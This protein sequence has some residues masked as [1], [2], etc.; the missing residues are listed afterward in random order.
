MGKIGV[1]TLPLSSNNYGGIVQAYALQRKLKEEG[2]ADV[3]LLDRRQNKSLKNT[4]IIG[5]YKIF[6]PKYLKVHETIN[7]EFR[8]FIKKHIKS[9]PTFSSHKNLV[10]FIKTH[11]IDTLVT[12]SDQVWRTKYAKTIYK[13][14]FLD[15]DVPNK[16]SYAASLGVEHWEDDDKKETVKELIQDFKGISVREQGVINLFKNEF[17]SKAEQHI[18]PT[19]LLSKED[20]K[21]DLN[22]EEKNDVELLTYILDPQNDKENFI[23]NFASQH[24]LKRKKIGF[25]NKINRGNYKNF[26]TVKHDSI[27]HWLSSFMSAK[28]IIVDSFHGV[29]FSILFN[30]PFIAIGNKSRGLSRFNSILTL[31]KIKDRLITDYNEQHFNLFDKSID[32][33]Q[34][35]TILE[36]ERF[37]STTYLRNIINL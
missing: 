22:L 35:N 29:V 27:Y 23:N 8:N 32:F 34:I 25:K 31:F 24:G 15:F 2:A 12:G 14:L 33:E 18:D 37:K 4:F 13:D 3:V 30:V 10:N 21:K 9:S 6:Y 26:L 19:M 1:L 11:K 16:F 17:D 7:I 28:F 5:V 36:K 20:Y